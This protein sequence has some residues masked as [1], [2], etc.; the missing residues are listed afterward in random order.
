MSFIIVSNELAPER[1]YTPSIG[2]VG[3]IVDRAH[4]GML[5]NGFGCNPAGMIVAVDTSGWYVLCG[6]F[7][8]KS[9]I[10]LADKDEYLNTIHY[11]DGDKLYTYPSNRHSSVTNFV[12]RVAVR[13]YDSKIIGRIMIMG[14][15]S[16]DGWYLEFDFNNSVSSNI[17]TKKTSG[18]QR[19]IKCLTDYPYAEESNQPDG[20]F[21]CWGCRNF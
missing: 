3:S 12:S 2:L 5:Y 13:N 4:D 11:T 21:K 1:V 7:K 9:S 15:Y 14:S 20:T 10:V 16:H 19:C 8:I 6:K 18:P 17:S